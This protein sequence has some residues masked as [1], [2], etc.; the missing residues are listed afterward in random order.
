MNPT[1]ATLPANLYPISYAAQKQLIVHYDDKYQLQ[2]GYMQARPRPCFTSDL[3]RELLSTYRRLEQTGTHAGQPVKYHV[4]ASNTPGVFNL[5]GDLD[6]FRHLI[7]TRDRDG[8][9]TYATACI[10]P[11]YIA[12]NGFGRDITFISLVQGSA[13]GGGFEAALAADVLIAERGSR[14]GLPEILF[15]LFPGMGAFSVLSRK[16][17]AAAAE[18]MILSGRMYAAEELY[19]MG[20][21]DV[22]AEE[23]QGESA[24]FDHIA[25]ENRA[26][27][28]FRALRSARKSC[29]PVT[30]DELLRITTIW[31]DA[32]LQLQRRDLRMMERLVAR[33]SQK[34]MTADA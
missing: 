24:V 21:V 4:L 28:G 33:Q 1:E 16:I 32:A 22:L 20:V 8:L 29:N 9:M 13:L 31:V 11:M 26:S 7:E 25:R 6:L 15:N 5:G 34:G 14:L 27:N 23:G 17:G 18:R 2:W 3:L 30:Y 12:M 19:E 10:D